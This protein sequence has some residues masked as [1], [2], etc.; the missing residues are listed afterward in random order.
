MQSSFDIDDLDD[1]PPEKISVLDVKKG[2]LH[3]ANEASEIAGSA[4]NKQTITTVISAGLTAIFAATNGMSDLPAAAA[5]MLMLFPTTFGILNNSAL[6]CQILTAKALAIRART[7]NEEIENSGA[8]DDAL[9]DIPEHIG[10]DVLDSMAKNG[11]KTLPRTKACYSVLAG[12]FLLGATYLA[13]NGN[14]HD[15][16]PH[17]TTVITDQSDSPKQND[18]VPAPSEPQ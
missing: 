11:C 1:T 2:L 13:T 6:N 5:G 12:V 10:Y 16:T 18:F 15:Q 8:R 14:Q 7:A 4:R 3:A 9:I 17:E